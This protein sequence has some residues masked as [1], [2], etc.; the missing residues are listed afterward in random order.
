MLPERERR[1]PRYSSEASTN[2]CIGDTAKCGM[3]RSDGNRCR[4]GPG[5]FC[6][7][8]A[9]GEGLL[10]ITNDRC[11]RKTIEFSFGE[12]HLRL[13]T[14]EPSGGASTMRLLRTK[15]GLADATTTG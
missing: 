1:R 13:I 6:R 15:A 4:E 7:E 8:R 9:P 11:Y 3:S 5:V 10:N 2:V 14:F 12:E